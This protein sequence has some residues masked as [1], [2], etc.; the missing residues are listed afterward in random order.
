MET[1]E[2][3][4]GSHNSGRHSKSAGNQRTCWAKTSGDRLFEIMWKQ[5]ASVNVQEFMY[6]HGQCGRKAE[7]NQPFLSTQ[8]NCSAIILLALSSLI[9]KMVIANRKTKISD[10]TCTQYI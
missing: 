10:I 6:V 4:K 8:C 1:D 7:E 3:S 9:T 5:T 2:G